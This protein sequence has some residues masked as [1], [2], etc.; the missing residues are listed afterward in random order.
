MDYRDA[1]IVKTN[2][3][4]PSLFS[5]DVLHPGFVLKFSHAPPPSTRC[6]VLHVFIRG[7]NAYIPQHNM[8]YIYHIYQL[9]FDIHNSKC[10]IYPKRSNQ[11]PM[12]SLSSSTSLL[13]P[14]SSS[15]ASPI[16]P[17]S[18]CLIKCVV[19]NFNRV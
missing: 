12:S 2:I 6:N 15:S 19:S 5:L 14:L 8:V 13:L 3:S 18:S 4:R 7:K 17:P 11:K 9:L 16:S 10:Y 1:Y